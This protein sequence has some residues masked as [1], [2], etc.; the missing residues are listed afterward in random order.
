MTQRSTTFALASPFS[1]Y[2]Y[3]HPQPLRKH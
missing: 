3:S 2:A 1:G